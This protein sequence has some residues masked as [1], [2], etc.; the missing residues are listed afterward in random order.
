MTIKIPKYPTITKTYLF[1]EIYFTKDVAQRIC[2]I[3][4]IGMDVDKLASG[5]SVRYFS[6]VYLTTNFLYNIYAYNGGIYFVTNASQKLQF[7]V[8]WEEFL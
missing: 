1:P 5:I 4:T 3:E 6:G 8:C 7:R 2:D